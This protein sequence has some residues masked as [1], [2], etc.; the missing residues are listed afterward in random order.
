MVQQQFS[1][2]VF[3][4]RFLLHVASER[5]LPVEKKAISSGGRDRD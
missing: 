3:A 2:R 5:S 4:S 1:N